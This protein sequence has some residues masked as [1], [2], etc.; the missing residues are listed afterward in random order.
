MNVPSPDATDLSTA[1]ANLRKYWLDQFNTGLRGLISA[2]ND[3]AAQ[4]DQTPKEI[5][6]ANATAV[7]TSQG[8]MMSAINQLAHVE[9]MESDRLGRTGYNSVVT[10]M[11][12]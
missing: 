6:Q 12:D 1:I 7:S 5:K 9:T 4:T 2:Q 11:T 8:Q 3:V 10:L